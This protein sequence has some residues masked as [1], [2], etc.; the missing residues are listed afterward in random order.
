MTRQPNWQLVANLGDVNPIDYGG[1]F[2]YIDLN[3]EYEPELE[4]LEVF[5]EDSD[6]PIWQVFR[7]ILS[8]CT[9][10]NGILSD[11]KYHPDKSAW[12][13]KSK[14]ERAARPQ[15]TTYLENVANSMDYPEEDMV[16]DLCGDNVI[17]RAMA[18][19]AIADYHGLDN[20]DSYPLQF[21]NMAEVE[22]RYAELDK[23]P[24]GFD[25]PIYDYCLDH[26]KAMAP[27]SC[28]SLKGWMKEQLPGVDSGNVDR[29]AREF[30][31]A[32][33]AMAVVTVDDEGY[34]DLRR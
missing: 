14:A 6:R 22:A 31:T 4:V 7:F 33:Q 20:F 1:Q 26:I 34:V 16:R 17:A 23:K 8:K 25:N 28:G 15:D 3:G 5:D 30:L 9:Y 19:K 13:A 21:T 11:N 27:L 18:Y 2:V 24:I 12:F 32:A 10:I 29:V